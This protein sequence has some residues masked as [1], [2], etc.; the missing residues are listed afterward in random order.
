[1]WMYLGRTRKPG[2]EAEEPVP[3]LVPPSITQ[4]MLRNLG[5]GA[6]LSFWVEVEAVGLG[7]TQTGKSFCIFQLLNTRQAP[8]MKST[9]ELVFT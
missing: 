9:I 4:Q 8:E 7:N 1:M 5:E 3:G 2:K 6:V